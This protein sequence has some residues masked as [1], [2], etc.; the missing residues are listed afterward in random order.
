MSYGKVL[1]LG[2]VLDLESGR[3]IIFPVDH[4]GYMGPIKGIERPWSTLKM[5]IESGV[6]SLLIHKGFFKSYCNEL[7]KCTK[8]VGLILRVSVAFAYLS[9]PDYETLISLPEEALILGADAVAFTLHVGGKHYNKAVRLFS[10]VV[11]KCD[12]WGIPVV[13]ECLPSRELGSNLEAVKTTVRVGAEL[14]ADIIK[15][16]YV[17]PFEEVVDVCPVPIVIAG[18]EKKDYKSVLEMVEKAVKA[19]AAGVCIGRNV[20]QHENP[21][22]MLKAIATIVKEGKSVEDALRILKGE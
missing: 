14:G 9:E 10:K 11:D 12:S 3:S 16:I 8:R 22:R 4:G 5:A 6:D 18:G 15:T 13:G 2:R 21:D 17:E 20:F 1:R 19:G 7:S